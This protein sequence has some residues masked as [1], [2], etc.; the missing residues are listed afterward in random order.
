MPKNPFACSECHMII[1]EE[2]KQSFSLYSNMKKVALV[3][4][5]ENRD[6]GKIG[7]VDELVER[8]I[9]SDYEKLELDELLAKLVECSP[10]ADTKGGKAEIISKLMTEYSKKYDPKCKHHPSAPV[11][12]D[13]TGYVVVLDPSRSEIANR[14]NIEAPG[15]YALKVNLR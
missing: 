4:E 7:K 3:E 13:W 1:P 8:L 10:Q 12:S 11:S 9:K 2:S 6:L 14:L 5:L 15:N